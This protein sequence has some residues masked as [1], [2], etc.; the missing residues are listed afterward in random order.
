MKFAVSRETPDIETSSA[1]YARRFSGRAGAYFLRVQEQAVK[2][3]LLGC[4]G[5]SVLDVG[6]GHGQL[7]QLL[8]DLGYCPTVI[9]SDNSCYSRLRSQC[10]DARLSFVTSDLLRL[11]YPDQS[12]DIVIAVRLISHISAWRS[13]ITEFCRIAKHSVVIDYPSWFSINAVTP[14][15]FAIKKRWEGNTRSYQSFFKQDLAKQF[16]SQGF[17]VTRTQPQFFLPMVLHRAAGG[18]SVLISME[19]HCQAIGLTRSFGSPVILRADR[20]GS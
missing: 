3:T 5:S 14:I 2:N 10:S 18:S 19:S 4:E 7:T 17:S 8:L 13:L 16:S 6:G 9:G 15:L 11:P 20:K 1:D 12:V